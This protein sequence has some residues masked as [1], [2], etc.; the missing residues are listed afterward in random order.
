[1]N[2]KDI[3]KLKNYQ[4]PQVVFMLSARV[5]KYRFP[6]FLRHIKMDPKPLNVRLNTQN[7]FF[8]PPVH[9]IS[10]IDNGILSFSKQNKSIYRY[11][12][13]RIV[14]TN[15]VTHRKQVIAVAI[16]PIVNFKKRSA[17]KKG[18]KQTIVRLSKKIRAYNIIFLV[19]KILTEKSPHKY[20]GTY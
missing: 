11:M 9:S 4:P 5:R 7:N 13:F 12:S 19:Y 17:F 10:C 8:L 18:K 1:M 6:L 20:I 14:S 2:L 3:A 15:K 16:F